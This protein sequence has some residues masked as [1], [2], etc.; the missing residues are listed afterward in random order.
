VGG[1]RVDDLDD[2]LARLEPRLG[3]ITAGPVPLEG[4]ITNRNYRVRFG[5]R[6]CVV[7]LPG[8]ET[9]LLGI[10][11]EAERIA[12][13]A[14]AKLGIAP[15]L[16]AADDQCLVTEYVDG[17]PADAA[18]VRAAPEALGDALRRFHDSGAELPIRF[19]VPELLENYA[20]V[21]LG[22]GGALPEAYAQARELVRRIA[23]L[24]PLSDPVPCHDDLLPA[25]VMR[26][27]DGEEI[28][29]VDWEYAG[30]GHRLF[31]LGN[32]A[33]NAEFEASEEV[34]LLAAYLDKEP[35]AADHAS[36]R[37][38]RIMSDAREAAWG[39]VQGSASELDFDFEAYA[40]RHFERLAAAASDPRLEEWLDAATA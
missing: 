1:R 26:V 39:V 29:L 9:A 5:E 2:V 32:V 4:G 17:A 13:Q 37:L 25:N 36:L 8:K 22:R 40:T 14:A 7:R 21:V 34:R 3:A 38:M 10:S 20:H 24:L 16:V 19:W 18:G 31:D 35:S 6:D 27:N 30:M 28:M 33:V 12:T 11:R 15:Q 23:E